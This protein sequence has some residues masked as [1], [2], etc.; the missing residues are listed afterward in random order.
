[1]PSRGP[2]ASENFLTFTLHQNP[3]I[4]TAYVGRAAFNRRPAHS[5]CP[6]LHV[7][8]TDILASSECDEEKFQLAYSFLNI[9][10]VVN[11]DII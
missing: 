11:Q 2:A 9:W 1:M 3:N 4:D 6:Y 10:T 8:A 5:T 7:Q